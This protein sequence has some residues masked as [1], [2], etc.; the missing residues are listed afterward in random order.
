MQRSTERILTTHTGSL[1]RPPDLVEMIRAREQG[2]SVDAAAFA[3]RTRSAGRE[4]VRKQLDSGLDIVGDGEMGKPSFATY[5]THRLAGF[6]GENPEIRTTSDREAFPNWA[7]DASGLVMKRQYCLE[8]LA[9][10][11]AESV[12][13]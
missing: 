1:P 6:G 11:G 13:S 12:Q 9:W 3:A 4:V 8:P 5:V 10:Q 7:S 2:E